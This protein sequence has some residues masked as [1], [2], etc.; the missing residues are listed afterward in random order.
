MSTGIADLHFGRC[1]STSCTVCHGSQ[2]QICQ[3]RM[4]FNLMKVNLINGCRQHMALRDGWR[5]ASYFFGRGCMSTFLVACLL[6]FVLHVL[7]V[8]RQ[9][10]LFQSICFPFHCITAGSQRCMGARARGRVAFSSPL[11]LQPVPVSSACLQRDCSF[12]VSGFLCAVI[13]IWWI[14]FGIAYVD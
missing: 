10:Y 12:F 8:S 7:A 5:V 14:L 1:L 6:C 9:Q 13:F 3:F 4:E 2:L 11:A